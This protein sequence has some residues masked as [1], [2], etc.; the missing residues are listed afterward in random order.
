MFKAQSRDSV[1]QYLA[2]QLLQTPGAGEYTPNVNF[3]LQH[4]HASGVM[5]PQSKKDTTEGLIKISDRVAGLKPQF[6]SQRHKRTL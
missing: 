5:F 2:N 6:I 3:V 1:N 4:K